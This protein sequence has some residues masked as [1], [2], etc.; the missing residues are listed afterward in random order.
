MNYP[1]NKSSTELAFSQG[2]A[3]RIAYEF[4]F[5]SNSEL[6]IKAEIGT[7]MVLTKSLLSVDSGGV[8]YSVVSGAIEGAPYDNLVAKFNRNNQSNVPSYASKIQ[9]YTGG[10]ITGGSDFVV[11]R[12]RTSSNSNARATNIGDASQ[13]R[14]FQPVELYLKLEPLNGVNDDCLGILELEWEENP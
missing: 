11:A 6:I 3:F 14:G 7:N 13:N 1:S 10:T 9:F 4:D 8:R 2:R 12:V 5:S